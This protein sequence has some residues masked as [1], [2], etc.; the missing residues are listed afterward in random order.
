[1]W[2]V[3]VLH[4]TVC[5]YTAQY[6]ACVYCT[7]LCVCVLY[8]TVRVC[9]AQYYACVYC[10][11]LGVCILHSTVRV[12]TAQYCACVYLTVLCVCVYWTKKICSTFNLNPILPVHQCLGL[13]SS[14]LPSWNKGHNMKDKLYPYLFRVCGGVEVWLQ[15]FLLLDNWLIRVSILMGGT[16][17][18]QQKIIYFTPRYLTANKSVSFGKNFTWE[19]KKIFILSSSSSPLCRVFILIFLR[20]TMSLRNTVLQLFCCYYS[21]CLYR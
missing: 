21:W 17:E 4:S 14:F 20:Q 3:C 11:V 6:C 10:T 1:M 16:F 2:E 13:P 9:T 15:G 12:C 7:V 8:S 19:W 18:I 5:V